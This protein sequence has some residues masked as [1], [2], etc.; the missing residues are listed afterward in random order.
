MMIG[1]T[2]IDEVVGPVPLTRLESLS[3]DSIRAMNKNP[4]NDVKFLKPWF[5]R[6]IWYA[7]VNPEY[8]GPRPPTLPEIVDGTYRRE[9]ILTWGVG[10]RAPRLRGIA[11]AEYLLSGDTEV[12]DMSVPEN[13]WQNVTRIERELRAYGARESRKPISEVPLSAELVSNYCGRYNLQ[14]LA[15]LML[16]ALHL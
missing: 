15:S 8:V 5:A 1:Q 3:L 10:N 7:H 2:R 4:P 11:I 6:E 16:E 14:P 13:Q 9:G 12:L